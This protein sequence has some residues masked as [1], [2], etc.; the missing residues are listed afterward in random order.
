M[1]ME[2]VRGTENIFQQGTFS[3]DGLVCLCTLRYLPDMVMLLFTCRHVQ[4]LR[5]GLPLA[6]PCTK[7][8]PAGNTVV[9]TCKIAVMSVQCQITR[10][11]L[12]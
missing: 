12:Q 10:E 5:T 2:D 6:P 3:P 11:M 1:G 8:P 9:S 4:P 7:P